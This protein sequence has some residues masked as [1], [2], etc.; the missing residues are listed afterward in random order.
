M[1]EPT[2]VMTNAA[3]ELSLGRILLAL[4]AGACTGS[5]LTT[6]GMFSGRTAAPR[7]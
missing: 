4:L 2:A 3:P 5:L 6:G 7:P 1:S